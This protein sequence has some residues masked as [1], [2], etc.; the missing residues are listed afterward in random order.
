MSRPVSKE[1]AGRRL[2][3]CAGAALLLLAVGALAAEGDDAPAATPSPAAPVF[4]ILGEKVRAGRRLNLTL[5]MG[6]SFAGA[7]MKIPVSVTHGTRPGPVTCLVAGIHGDEL[8]GVEIVRRTVASTSPR[9]L[10]GVLVGVPIANLHGLQRGSRYLPDRRDLNR[11]F[12]GRRTGSAASRIADV[13]FRRIVRKCDL[14]LDFHTGS[15]RRTN[16][17]QLRADLSD[18]GVVDLARRLGRMPVVNNAGRTGTLRRAAT[19]IGI[20]AV[21]Y[22]A[23]EPLRF[24]DDEIQRGVERAKKLLRELHLPTPAGDDPS[25]FGRTRWVR[26][27]QGGI[28]MSRVELGDTVDPGD[29]LGTVTNPLNDEQTDVRA[30]L[31]GTLIGMAVN[32]VVIPGFAAYHLGI[33]SAAA[34]AGPPETP[35][36]APED[37]D[38]S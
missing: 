11:F 26:V 25:F 12:P 33:T 6:E 24:D 15:L 27:D 22:E 37:D 23:G 19:D 29:V 38:A 34:E 30:P 17:S 1:V 10:R 3:G 18:A 8:N 2:A 13:L 9:K 31:R 32:Q 36:G 14:V 5:R 21:T 16:L 35:D 20:A 28:L 4:E 7:P